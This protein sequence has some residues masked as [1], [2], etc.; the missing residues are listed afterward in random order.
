MQN[1]RLLAERLR[2]NPHCRSAIV[3]LN[4]RGK[5]LDKMLYAVDASDMR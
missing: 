4:N 1:I 5:I 2:R 3:F